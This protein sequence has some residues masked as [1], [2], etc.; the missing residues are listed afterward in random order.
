MCCSH[1]G[2]TEDAEFVVFSVVLFVNCLL[3]HRRN[4]KMWK[5]GQAGVIELWAILNFGS[6]ILNRLKFENYLCIKT[7]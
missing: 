1:A 5:I 6:G 7:L 4:A 3:I 2:I